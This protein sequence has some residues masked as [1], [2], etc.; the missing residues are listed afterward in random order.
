MPP[1]GQ[2]VLPSVNDV[3]GVLNEDVVDAVNVESGVN[4]EPVVT[5]NIINESGDIAVNV[6]IVE[7][8]SG[9][10][11]TLVNENLCGL[12]MLWSLSLL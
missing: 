11:L 5:E 4:S 10:V 6:E 3:S 9:G 8:V 2:D 12:L 1:S 7:G